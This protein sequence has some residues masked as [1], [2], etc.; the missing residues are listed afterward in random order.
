MGAISRQIAEEKYDVH[1]VNA[2]LLRE[3]GLA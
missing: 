1:K 3:M 2:V